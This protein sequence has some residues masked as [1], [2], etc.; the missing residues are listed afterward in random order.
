MGEGCGKGHLLMHANLYAHCPKCW[1]DHQILDHWNYTLFQIIQCLE[2]LG[3]W[4][5]S[6][7]KLTVFW[8]NHITRCVKSRTWTWGVSCFKLHSI[9]YLI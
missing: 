7:W 6:K 1:G 9:W 5:A 4:L 3:L 8:I 2:I